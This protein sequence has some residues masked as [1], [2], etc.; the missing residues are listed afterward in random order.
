M[1]ETS[2]VEEFLTDPWS[3]RARER[4]TVQVKVPRIAAPPPPPTAADGIAAG[5]GD[6]ALSA[7]TKRA[8]LQRRAVA[9]SQA[10]ED[11]ARRL[12]NGIAKVR[13]LF[14]LIIYSVWI[15]LALEFGI[16]M[17]ADCFC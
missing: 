12:E 9:A 2:R 3:I 16:W 10:A 6:E 4:A 7:Q 1:E 15:D 13:F 17:L 11:Y 14:V 5:D 8:L